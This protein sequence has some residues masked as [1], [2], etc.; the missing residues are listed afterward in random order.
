MFYTKKVTRLPDLTVH[1]YIFEIT[2]VDTRYRYRIA[3]I[4]DL[5]G[6]CIDYHRIIRQNV[7]YR[8]SPTW[9]VFMSVPNCCFHKILFQSDTIPYSR[10]Y[11]E[12]TP[13][14]RI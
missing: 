8:I 3:A 9:V 6:Y 11:L 14:K 13:K 2:I 7:G 5:S 10:V 12:S 1:M 4:F